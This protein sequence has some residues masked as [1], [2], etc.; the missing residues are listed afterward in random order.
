MRRV[1]A[2]VDGHWRDSLVGAGDPVCLGLNFQTNLFEVGEF[3]P[4]A[5]QELGIFC[6]RRRRGEGE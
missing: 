6:P 1:D 5:V 2:E 4:L 3:L